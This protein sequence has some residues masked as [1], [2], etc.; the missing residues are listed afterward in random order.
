MTGFSADLKQVCGCGWAA[1]GESTDEVVFKTKEHALH[2]HELKEIPAD[3][4]QKLQAAIRPA[5]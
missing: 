5:I 3:V 1:T 4:A 2:M